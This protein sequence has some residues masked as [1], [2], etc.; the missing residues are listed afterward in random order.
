MTKV[1]FGGISGEQLR[2]YIER[3]EQLEQEKQDIADNIRDAFAEAKGN[4]F[5][6]KVM[7]Q[8]IKIRKMKPEERDEQET[9]LDLYKHAL[10]MLPGGGERDK[11][12]A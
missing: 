11:E 4:G 5:D 6:V 3:I 7:R 8:L 2:Q 10:G 1:K 12:A 9:V